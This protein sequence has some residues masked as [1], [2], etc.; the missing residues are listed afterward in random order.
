[1]KKFILPIAA[2]TLFTACGGGASAPKEEVAAEE[3]KVEA[4]EVCTYSYDNESTEVLW[5]AYK[6]TEKTGVKGVFDSVVVSGVNEGAMPSDVLAGAE[7]QIY[8]GSVNS[9]DATRDPKIKASFFGTMAG[10][11]EIITGKVASIEGNET[12]GKVVFNVA[13]NGQEAQ[14]PGSYTVTD[15][16]LE[17]EADITVESWN[18]KGSL[19]ELNKVCEDLHKGQDG[20]SILWPDVKLFVSTTLKKACE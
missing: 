15:N 2:I 11:G 1:M 7:F 16:K 6:Y 12:E 4:K 10:G 20:K 17:V 8:T 9:G 5:V 3:P 13:M 14:V 19:D 18:A